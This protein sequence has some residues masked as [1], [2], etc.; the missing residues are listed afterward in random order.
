MTNDLLEW[1]EKAG[2]ENLRFRLQNSET[3]AKEAA[4]TLTVLMAGMAGSLAYAAKG[5]EQSPPTS[6][7]VGAGVL[8]MWL[9]IA[10][11]MLVIFCMLTTSLP[12][13]TNEPK[14]LYQKDFPLE[15]IRQ[16]EL[17]NLQE[18]IEQTAARNHRVAA[19]LDRCRLLA[20]ASPLVFAIAAFVWAAR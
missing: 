8:A 7:A 5:F 20:L 15:A 2:Q 18:R 3:L 13:P 12:A 4:W 17:R 19:W 14:N 6:L 1:V 11:F 16:V 9:M 10:G